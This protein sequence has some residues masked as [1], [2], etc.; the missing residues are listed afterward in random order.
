MSR[1]F[2]DI[3]IGDPDKFAKVTEEY[4]RAEKFLES[5]GAMVRLVGGKGGIIKKLTFFFFR[6]Q[7]FFL[8]FQP[9]QNQKKKKKN[10]RLPSQLGLSSPLSSLDEEARS[11][12]LESYDAD[13]AWS[14]KGP[15]RVEKP[16]PLLAGRLVIE[17][18]GGGG[19]GGGSGCGA[20]D[21]AEKARENFRCL[22]TGEKGISKNAKR[23]LHYK[24]VAFHRIVKGFV[25]QGGDVVR[26]D[27]SGAESVWGGK[28]KDEP[29]ALKRKHDAVG[30]V[31]MANGG[32]K[33]GSACQFYVTLAPGLRRLDG[34]HVVVGRVVPS[35]TDDGEKGGKDG[36]EGKEEGQ[37]GGLAL[38][39]RIEREAA[40][41]SGEPRVRVAI[42]D[43]GEC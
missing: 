31:G 23:P 7:F 10:A 15:A 30:V 13:P 25:A 29:A 4:S 12:L 14:S 41:E 43:C 27:G 35:E 6:R 40:S 18:F 17:L 22:C 28:F 20:A 38:L 24:G 37:Q 5:N 32:A 16:R 26:G 8:L 19:G 1:V 2:F 9:L 21:G 3:E 36:K 42:A 39:R 33:N 11:L 34:K